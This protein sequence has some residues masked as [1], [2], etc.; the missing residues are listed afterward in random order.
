[1]KNKNFVFNITITELII[2][3]FFIIS[4]LSTTKIND[5]NERLENIQKELEQ[6]NEKIAQ[7]NE[8]VNEQKNFILKLINNPKMIDYFDELMNM[9]KYI[10]QITKISLENERLKK[11]INDLNNEQKKFDELEKLSKDI[12]E[13][14]NSK[15]KLYLH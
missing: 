3:L 5:K 12:N 1:M 13:Q 4:L 9:Q 11:I 10:E 6:K 2:L 15:K 8:K 14:I 7:L